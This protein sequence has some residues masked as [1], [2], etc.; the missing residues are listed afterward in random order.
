METAEN[1]W[2]ALHKWLISDSSSLDFYMR[3]IQN[4]SDLCFRSAIVAFPNQ[5]FVNESEAEKVLFTFLKNLHIT[6]CQFYGWDPL[7]DKFVYSPNF[8]FSLCGIAHFVPLM[9]QSASSLVRRTK[10]FTYVVFNP[11]WMFRDLRDCDLF[12]KFKKGIRSN[13]SKVQY[14]W[15]NPKLADHGKGSE[16]AQ[17]ALTLNPV[18]NIG[19]CPFTGIE[20]PLNESNWEMISYPPELSI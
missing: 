1:V 13:E 18:F 4:T 2:I 16:A 11:H 7:V 5:N 20:R 6:D 14:G 9:H 3:R 10:E 15:I 19:I 17:Y 8:G 12:D